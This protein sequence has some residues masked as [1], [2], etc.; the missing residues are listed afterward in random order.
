MVGSAVTCSR[1]LRLMI[2]T[3]FFWLLPVVG[4][5]GAVGW[6][7]AKRVE[8]TAVPELV[9]ILHSFVGLAAVLVGMASYFEAGQFSGSALVIHEIEII[10][11]VLIGA[12]T[13]TGSVINAAP[14]M[15]QRSATKP[16]LRNF[17]IPCALCACV[18]SALDPQGEGIVGI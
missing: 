12:Y 15:P 2:P 13:F 8:M 18:I 7:V 9:A 3:G 10:L 14:L 5:G 6:A 17:A 4:I 11:G 16:S 1:A